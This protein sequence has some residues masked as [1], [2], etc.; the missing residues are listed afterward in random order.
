MDSGLGSD[1]ERRTSNG[2]TTTKEQK[3]LHNQ[4]LL[5]G[6]FI[7]A[8]SLTDDG[9]ISV[10]RRRDERRQ[11]AL[12]FQTSI[13]QFS[14]LQMSSSEENCSF[15]VAPSSSCSSVLPP[16]P[17]TPFNSFVQLENASCKSPLGFYVDLNDV[18]A[19][20][21]PSSSS[22]TATKNIFSM[23]IDFEAPKKDMPSRLSSSLIARRK[24]RDKKP[25]KN[26]DNGSRSLSAASSSSSYNGESLMN[27]EGK[28]GLNGEDAV[29]HSSSSSLCSSSN[30][31]EGGHS[32]SASASDLNDIAKEK[33][34]AENL[35]AEAEEVK[36][37]REEEEQ[38][39]ESEEET[40][41]PNVELEEKEQDDLIEKH[42]PP[43]KEV[44]NTDS[45]SQVSFCH[46]ND[47]TES[48]WSSERR[49]FNSVSYSSAHLLKLRQTAR[50]KTAVLYFTA[51]NGI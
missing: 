27:V 6:C 29:R 12:I 19:E 2:R 22:S 39:E 8:S 16:E 37:K 17:N 11:G 13:P 26:G 35:H 14:M 41:Q 15:P 50:L 33:E 32:A 46:K 4:R 5:S 18:P 47:L 51:K 36:F 10:E 31:A 42:S 40:K 21:P 1:E 20:P 7:D 49:S 28:N 38:Q 24:V 3:Q 25:N 44:E 9:D 23:V 43:H 34:V 48:L 30:N 45:E